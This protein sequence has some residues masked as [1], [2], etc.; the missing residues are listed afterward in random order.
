MKHLIL[1]ITTYL[2]LATQ[3]ACGT[4]LS[5]GDCRPPLMWLPVLLALSW[6]TDARGLVWAAL[7]GLLSDGLSSGRFGVEMLATTLTAAMLLSL[8]PE[9]EVD[10]RSRWPRLVWQFS[11]I[12]TGLLLSQG[13]GC[14]LSEGQA[15]T[16]QTLTTLA[17]EAAYGL[18]LCV[19]LSTFGA[20]RPNS[21]ARYHHA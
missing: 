16:L 10:V 12:A 14:V 3:A 19:G 1:L 5:I 6:F 17:G 7:I 8:R 21:P 11:L 15:M 2:A 9:V 13:L 20:L 18:A 4:A